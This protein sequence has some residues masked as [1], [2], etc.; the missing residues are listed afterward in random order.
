MSLAHPTPPHPKR[1]LEMADDDD[2]TDE[3]RLKK[4]PTTQDRRVMDYASSAGS[5]SEPRSPKREEL[6]PPTAM[7]NKTEVSST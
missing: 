7:L 4:A 5:Q 1:V 6:P 3:K 2:D